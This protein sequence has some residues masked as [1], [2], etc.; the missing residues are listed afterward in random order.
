MALRLHN[1]LS[2]FPYVVPAQA[3]THWAAQRTNP[4]HVMSVGPR[5]R[6]GDSFVAGRAWR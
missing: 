3:G 1:T 4:P 5:L 6:G 2:A